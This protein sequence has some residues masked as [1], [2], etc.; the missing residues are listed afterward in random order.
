MS[1]GEIAGPVSREAV[2]SASRKPTDT[3]IALA[4]ELKRRRKACGVSQAWLA[5]RVGV[6]TQQWGKY[7]RGQDRLP[8]GRHDAAWRLL[9][10]IE[11]GVPAAG[12][13]AEPDQPAYAPGPGPSTIEQYLQTIRDAIDGLEALLRQRRVV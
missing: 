7:E 3:D 13:L 9:K 8:V 12:Q 4:Q 2:L 10:E 1:F 5:Q 6:S 11:G